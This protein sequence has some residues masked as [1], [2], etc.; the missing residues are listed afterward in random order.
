M[1]MKDTLVHCYWHEW[2]VMNWWNVIA[3]K[4]SRCTMQC[5]P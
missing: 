3:C 1:S 2:W 4:L 5:L